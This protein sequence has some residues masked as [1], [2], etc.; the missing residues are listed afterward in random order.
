M[1]AKADS[2]YNL[3]KKISKRAVK[4]HG[5]FTYICFVKLTEK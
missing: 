3:S 1:G 5:S 2:H 4:I